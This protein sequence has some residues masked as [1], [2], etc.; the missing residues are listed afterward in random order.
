MMDFVKNWIHFATKAA[1][2]PM[3]I[4]AA[5]LRLLTACTDMGVPAAAI[6]PELDVWT[7]QRKPKRAEVYEM[8][9]DWAYMRHHKSDFL[10]MGLVKVAFLWELLHVG[11]SVLIS[12]LD[13]VWLNGHWQRWM[14]WADAANP[15]VPQ[16]AALAAADVLVTTDELDTRKDETGTGHASE[17]N[18]GVIYLRATKG[19]QAMVQSWRKSM[20]RQR[21]RTDL[22]ENVNDQSLFNQV[23]RGSPVY[24]LNAWQGELRAQN[25]TIPQDAFK[26][27]PPNV[28]QVLRTSRNHEPCL[29]GAGC[30]PMSFTYGTLPIRPFTGG[31]TWFN[32]NVQEMPGHELPQ[33]EPITVHF[34]FQFGDTKEYPHGKRQRAREAALW[35]VDPPEYF[36]E[37][38]FVALKGPSYDTEMMDAVYKRFPE[39]SPQRHMFMDA[40]QRQAVRELLGPTL[41]PHSPMLSCTLL[42]VAC[43]H[44]VRVHTACVSYRCATSSG[45][46]LPSTV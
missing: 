24:D 41:C 15:P 4:G 13:V 30:E 6:I 27:L 23:V 37:G 8:R 20:L 10:E 36:T 32:Q 19:A 3:L 40:P 11:F 5:D 2:T 34:T 33:H 22:T 46:R 29:P 38:V 45:S 17:L 7:Y 12:D 14:T 35:A 25:V 26:G 9:S 21:G 31:H 28:R 16:A 18:T 43:A 42:T 1:L 44:C 39:W